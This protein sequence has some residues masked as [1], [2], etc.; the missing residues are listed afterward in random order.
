M[1]GHHYY[2]NLHC[3]PGGNLAEIDRLAPPDLKVHT[4]YPEQPFSAFRFKNDV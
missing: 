4:G 3:P 1:Y 2:R